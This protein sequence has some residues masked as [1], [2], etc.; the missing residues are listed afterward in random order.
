MWFGFYF[1]FGFTF[2]RGTPKWPLSEFFNSL[3]EHFPLSIAR[4]R[5]SGEIPRRGGL[6][7]IVRPAGVA[8]RLREPRQQRQL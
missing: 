6:F 5:R 4:S 2:Y 3:L 8:L 7:E 1:K